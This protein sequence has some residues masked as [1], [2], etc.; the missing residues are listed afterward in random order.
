MHQGRTVIATTS[1]GAVAGG[2][3]RH[4]E[5]GWVVPAGD[6][7]ALAGAI[8]HLLADPQLRARLGRAAR[9]AVAPYTYD[10]M[11]TAFDRALLAD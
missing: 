9:T 5:T 11:V 8:E 2:L 3:V 10:A 6:A 7:R 4:E 1:V